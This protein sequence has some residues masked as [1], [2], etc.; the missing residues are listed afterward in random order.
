ME[1]DACEPPAFG[2]LAVDQRIDLELLAHDAFDQVAEEGR[3]CVRILATLDLLPEP[4]RLELGDDL[5]QVD[6]RHVHLVERLHGGEA[7]GAT[8][9]RAVL[10]LV[11]AAP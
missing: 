1:I 4:V 5:C 11:C 10:R 3:L 9:G 6:P 7:R 8:R 2:E